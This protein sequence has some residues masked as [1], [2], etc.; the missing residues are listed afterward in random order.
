[1]SSSSFISHTPDHAHTKP[2]F[3][4]P[5]QE[6]KKEVAL[7]VL[8]RLFLLSTSAGEGGFCGERGGMVGGV[9]CKGESEAFYVYLSS[10]LHLVRPTKGGGVVGGVGES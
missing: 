2:L 3:L 5:T 10:L 9:F 8:L 6:E 1:M 4:S 7:T